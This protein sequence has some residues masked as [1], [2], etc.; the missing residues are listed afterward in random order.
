[1]LQEKNKLERED[2]E[3]QKDELQVRLKVNPKLGWDQVK[4]TPHIQTTKEF[5]G[6]EFKKKQEKRKEK[7]KKLQLIS[8]RD[9]ECPIELL[10]RNDAMKARA[11]PIPAPKSHYYQHHQKKEE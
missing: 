8:E 2:K 3:D 10:H 9:L 7:R 4:M 5:F 1:M 11:F 6:I